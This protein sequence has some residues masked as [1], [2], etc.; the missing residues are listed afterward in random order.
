MPH[1]VRS[2]MR[3]IDLGVRFEQSPTRNPDMQPLAGL[4]ARAY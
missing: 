2:E 3:G 1:S 4:D